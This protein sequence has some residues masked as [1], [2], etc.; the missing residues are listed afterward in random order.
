MVYA[1]GLSGLLGTTLLLSAASDLL[2]LLTLHVFVFYLLIASLFRWH[3]SMLSA[4]FNV[5]RGTFP[6]I[7][8]LPVRH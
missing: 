5:F 8:S 1:V 4:L 3:L 6:S 7:F 2:A